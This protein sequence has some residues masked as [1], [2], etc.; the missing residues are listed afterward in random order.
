MSNF[1]RGLLAA[2]LTSSLAFA[3]A[4]AASAEEA[5]TTNCG[6]PKAEFTATVD[7]KEH[8]FKKVSEFLWQA[9]DDEKVELSRADIFDLAKDGEDVCDAESIDIDDWGTGNDGGGSDNDETDGDDESD[10]NTGGDD[11]ADNDD[12]SEGGDDDADNDD[13]SEGGDGG[14]DADNGDDEDSENG[15]GDESE[16]DKDKNK[17]KSSFDGIKNAL[18]SEDGKPTDLGIAA[19][20]IGVLGAL[21]AIVPNAA[22]A[23]GIKLP[24]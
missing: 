17:D 6:S 14:D 7:G 2:T 19:I 1:S 3:G 8:T 4:T 20:V 23:L 22:R 11:D 18:S 12:E 9:T 13:E 15:D 21:A 16:G 5:A 24:F 10:G